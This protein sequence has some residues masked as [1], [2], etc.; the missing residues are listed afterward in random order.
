MKLEAILAE[1]DGI[2][3]M[4]KDMAED[5]EDQIE[6]LENELLARMWYYHD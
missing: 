2:K 5:Y 6:E 1:L 3:A 4:V